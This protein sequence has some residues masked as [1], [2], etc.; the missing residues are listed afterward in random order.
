MLQLELYKNP[1]R[2]NPAE[3]E[4]LGLL[5]ELDVPLWRSLA[6]GLSGLFSP[7]P[8]PLQLASRPVS[9]RELRLDQPL[10]RSLAANLGALLFPEKLPPLQLQ[11]KPAKVRDIW[12]AYDNRK[13]GWA[14]TVLVHGSVAVAIAAFYLGGGKVVEA[15][16]HEA[17][18]L[19]P[20]DISDYLPLSNKKHDTIGGGGGGGDRD[21]LAAPKG[22]LPKLAME[23][24]APPAVIVR[25]EHPKLP[26]EPTVVIPPQVKLAQVNM[27]TFGDPVAQVGPPSNGTGSGG[28]IGSG[29]GGG[30]GS[31]EGPGV[32]PGRG[33]GIGGGIFRVGGGVSAPRILYQPD[34]EYSEQARKAKYEGTVTLWLI[35]GPDGRPHDI[36]I[37][38]SLGMGLD[39]KAVEAV[40][41]WKF[42]PAR[43]SGQAVSVQINVE[44][45]FRLY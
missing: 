30:V 9:V 5:L 20:T 7:A 45:E 44:V 35:V 14:G 15:R 39:E 36:R 37:S 24:L 33:G 18:V 12:G 38:R 31:G 1:R 29:S 26:V 8:A 23:Q 34:P 27:P 43:K 25:N 19:I 22:K 28:G 40:R 32:G 3:E 11:S 21:K 4:D 41:Q 6:R 10:W 16:R 2:E 17:V 13:S 42:E